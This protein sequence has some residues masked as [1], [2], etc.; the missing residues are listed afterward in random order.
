MAASN[1]S[2]TKTELDDRLRITQHHSEGD[3][4]ELR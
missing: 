2:G 1:Y 3:I 4:E